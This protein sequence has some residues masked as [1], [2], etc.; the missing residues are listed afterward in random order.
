MAAIIT[1]FDKADSRIKEFRELIYTKDLKLDLKYMDYE[2][3]DLHEELKDTHTR[4]EIEDAWKF[5]NVKWNNSE[6]DMVCLVPGVA[7]SCSYKHDDTRYRGAFLTYTMIDQR[8][9]HHSLNFK[10][11]GF[12]FHQSLRAIDLGLNKLIITVYEYDKKMSANVRA[13]KH[14]GYALKAG[15]IIHQELEYTGTELIR[16]VDQHVFELDFHKLYL[17]YDAYLLD[18]KSDKET[19]KVTAKYPTDVR[20]Y[21]DCVKLICSLDLEKLVEDYKNFHDTENYVTAR[22]KDLTISPSIN[23]IVMSY[24]GFR[25]DVYDG[26]SLNKVR[27]HE[28]KES[29]GE[30]T[31]QFLSQFDNPCRINYITTTPGWITKPHKDHEDYTEQGFRVIVPLTGEMKMSFEGREVILYPGNAYFVNVCVEHVGEHFSQ[32]PERTGLLFKLSDDEIIW[33]SV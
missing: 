29:V 2:N 19:F 16:G 26:K 11:F 32:L 12:L 1:I 8:K 33:D 22:L 25:A 15:N 5:G 10:E 28:L 31:R 30:Y 3:K 27:S 18:M 7:M 23:I 20:Q 14:K 4:A 17:K 13:L 6:I 9:R 21:P 24:L